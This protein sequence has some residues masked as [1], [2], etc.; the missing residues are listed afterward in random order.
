MSLGPGTSHTLHCTKAFADATTMA[1]N[2]TAITSSPHLS[3][4]LRQTRDRWMIISI[5]P[6]QETE[7]WGVYVQPWK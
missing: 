5:C 2:S 1:L 3:H 4:S 6:F 7:T